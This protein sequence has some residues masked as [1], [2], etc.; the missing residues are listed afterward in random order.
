MVLFHVL[1]DLLLWILRWPNVHI[2]PILISMLTFIKKLIIFLVPVGLIFILPGIVVFFGREYVSVKEV[3][4]I[5]KEFP[6]SL[7]G[8]SYSETP[9]FLYK[10][11]IV[12]DRNSEVIA[13]G[14]SRVMQIR[15]E[16]FINPESF[17]NA[18][19]AARSLKEAKDFIEQLPKESN[20]KVII[21][22]IDQEVLYGQYSNMGEMNEKSLVDR[23]LDTS[24]LDSRRM[25]LDYLAHKY[26][27]SEI[28]D[29][30]KNKHDIGL[31]AIIN[32]DGFREDGSY[33]YTKE[34]N[35]KNL[36]Q[37]V[38]GQLDKKI[39][40]I[41][42]ANTSVLEYNSKEL[43]SNLVVIKEILEL[44]KN[45]NIKVIGFTPPIHPGVYEEMLKSNGLYHE[46]VV[47]GPK[48]TEEVF[49]SHGDVFFDLSRLSVF[50]GKE[51]EFVD[52]VHGTDVMYLRMM[53]YLTNH[54]NILNKYININQLYILLRSTEGA[55]LKF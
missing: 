22:G 29:G 1:R 13:L 38:R 40:V 34:E 32:G 28:I 49:S 20:V 23:V 10:K 46:M 21:L 44:C 37:T 14:T 16:F 53:I 51:T 19:G 43:Q 2:F 15:K 27:I 17:V 8:F 33:K 31:S 48:M 7:F 30:Y 55:F 11:L 18:G 35:D 24:V 3:V 52:G 12:E 26:S 6:S 42:N 9:F 50:G 39:E 25:Y 36:F 5:Q 41:K 45:K 54:T 47:T 4:K